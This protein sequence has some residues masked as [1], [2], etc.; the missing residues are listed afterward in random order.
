MGFHVGDLGNRG[1]RR[2]RNSQARNLPRL[3]LLPHPLPILSGA[4]VQSHQPDLVDQRHALT[5]ISAK[6]SALWM[7]G[8]HTPG[9][10]DESHAPHLG[11]LAVVLGA[12]LEID[13][14]GHRF[15]LF[16]P[17]FEIPNL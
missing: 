3:D 4:F 11:F 1:N 13:E 5:G 8:Q 17:Q 7:S 14:E 16:D 2:L 9:R 10:A 15:S 12:R 6:A